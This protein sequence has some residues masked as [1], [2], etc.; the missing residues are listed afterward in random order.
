MA[1]LIVV[2]GATGQQGSSVIRFLSKDGGFNIR[3]IT[4]NSNSASAKA[5]A[6]EGIE[7]VEADNHNPES[8]RAAFKG[9][10]GVFGVTN[11]W[12]KMDADSEIQ[13]GKAIVDAAK[14]E[15]VKHF[16][17]STLE[18]PKQVKVAHW[19]SKAKINEYLIAS[20]VPRT[21][22]YT[23]MYYENYAHMLTV[24][25]EETGQLVANWPLV[26]TDG[27]AVSF[28][29]EDIGGFALEAFKHPNKWI[30][31]DM[32]VAGEIITPRHVVQ[33]LSELSKKPIKLVE[34]SMEQFDNMDVTPQ[35]E[36]MWKNMK[37]FYVNDG[38][39]KDCPRDLELSKQ[40]YPGVQTFRMWA[41]KHLSELI[42][43]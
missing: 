13:Q 31:K 36:D 29:V 22:L 20:G 1:P 27:P 14:A 24:K 32:P 33:T 38:N 23:S 15:G 5:L 17:W 37:Y 43:A 30:G 3:G 8:L 42:P 7:V 16:V 18:D 40:A 25:K 39:P 11:Y 2:C 6:T 9:A 34:V 28:S 19:T 41:E 10:Y 26:A 4:R 12:E 35:M 21:S